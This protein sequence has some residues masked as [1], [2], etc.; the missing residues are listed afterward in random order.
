MS[1]DV[2]VISINERSTAVIE[3]TYAYSCSKETWDATD[4]NKSDGER[5]LEVMAS[6]DPHNIIDGE[7]TVI[8]INCVHD[9][10]VSVDIAT[11]TK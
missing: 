10:D 7:T 1:T 6:G 3:Q 9:K 8:D 2:V 11:V 4:S 5:L